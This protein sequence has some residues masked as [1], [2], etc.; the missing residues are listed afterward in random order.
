MANNILESYFVRVVAMPDGNSFLRLSRSLLQVQNEITG[1]VGTAIGTMVKYEAAVVST[2]A[3]VG[4]GLIAMADKA[5]MTDQSYRLLGL[6][7]LMTKDSFQAFQQAL[8]DV[9]VTADQAAYD[10]ESNRRV[11]EQYARNMRL[12]QQLGPDFEK[13]MEK[14]RDI[15]IQVKELGRDAQYL[16]YDVINK[17]FTKLG[18]G[19]DDMS[20]KL[21]RLN[22]WFERNL[23]NM[24]DKVSDFL[25]PVWNDAKVVLTDFGD[26]L[27]TVA[28]DF[29]YLMGVLSGDD[30]IT[31]TTF[32]VENLGKAFKDMFDTITESVLA[33]DVDFKTLL[34]FVTG[35]GLAVQSAR[36]GFKGN[37]DKA[38]ELSQRSYDQ[39][40]AGFANFTDDPATRRELPDFK[41][42]Q[43]YQDSKNQIPTADL[44]EM[45]KKYSNQYGLDPELAAA[46][47]YRES[48]NN[49]KVVSPTGAQGLMQLMP[50]TAKQYGVTDSFDPDQNLRGGIHYLS[51]LMKR[52]HGDKDLVLAAY[53]AGPGAV[54]KFGGIPPYEETRNYVKRV[55]GE[56]DTLKQK[57]VASGGDVI[58][59]S[60]SITVPPNTPQEKIQEIITN[61]MN[62]TIRKNTANQMAQTAGGAYY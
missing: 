18:F 31:D 21:E 36:E 6:R 2:F 28:G 42:Y 25:I 55:E 49:P 47:M 5:A 13:N 45:L 8:D 52:Y 37:T 39:I 60:I 56:Y 32:S 1:V 53:N 22:N 14:I 34:H 57:S 54:D 46:V 38:N 9:G 19:S 20:T 26:V 11:Q 58:I 48:G 15:R 61:S 62:D 16:E 41:R 29:S 33:L 7:M 23:P 35:T 17:L 10:P 4:L 12:Q 43:A 50:G 51:D 59:H 24:S 30:T 27:G 44:T 3:A 40:T